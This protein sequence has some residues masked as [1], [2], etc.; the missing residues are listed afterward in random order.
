MIEAELYRN[1]KSQQTSYGG[2]ENLMKSALAMYP[3]LSWVVEQP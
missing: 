3:C 2:S 1:K